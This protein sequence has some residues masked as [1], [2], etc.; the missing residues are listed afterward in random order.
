MWSILYHHVIT[1]TQ[2]RLVREASRRLLE[3]LATKEL[4]SAYPL[5]KLGYR[6]QFVVNIGSVVT[7][8]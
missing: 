2:L 4:W 1:P 6:A 7:L 3:A 5:G 8:L